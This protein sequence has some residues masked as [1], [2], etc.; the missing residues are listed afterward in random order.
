MEK[1]VI[2]NLGLRN[3]ELE[4]EIILGLLG[5]KGR[6]V[7]FLDRLNIGMFS[8]S[9]YRKSFLYIR[10]GFL[11]GKVV[12]IKSL[13]EKLKKD[14]PRRNYD[15]IVSKG[16][17]DRDEFSDI[18]NTLKQLEEKR[19]LYSIGDQIQAEVLA[20]RN[21]N[22][23]AGKIMLKLAEGFRDEKPNNPI[24]IM[25]TLKTELEKF[26]AGKKLVTGIKGLDDRL[27]A[28][29]K[30]HVWI[31]GARTGGGKSWMALQLAKNIAEQ[32]GHVAV[33]ST[34]MRDYENLGRIMGNEFKKGFHAFWQPETGIDFFET[35]NVK[36]YTKKLDSYLHIFDSLRTVEEI[37]AQCRK[38]LFQK[39]LNI[40]IIDFFQ[41]LDVR[42]KD[43]YEGF[44]RAA[45][46]LQSI[47]K[48]LGVTIIITSQLSNTFV[49]KAY[50][51]FNAVEYKNAGEIAASADV[52]LLLLEGREVGILPDNW[53]PIECVIAK[54]R[55]T[56]IREP[57]VP[58]IL[59]YPSGEIKDV[60]P[61]F[62]WIDKKIDEPD[63][64]FDKF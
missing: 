21:I 44:K 19:I 13:Y 26:H 52:G 5:S 23:I 7:E 61:E 42:G 27:P 18:V 1:S 20:D 32:E 10:K 39:K 55:H 36:Q 28:F 12:G 24:G 4:K 59:E 31:V 30:G 17:I 43:V 9:V 14:N 63:I 34:E 57:K 53:S 8:E 50:K 3:A 51:G 37:S 49:D 25:E 62:N 48:D 33:F 60:P 16:S 11:E 46:E 58:L 22:K 40:A 29:V 47:A 56:Y 2:Q 38:L 35:E 15:W 64:D 41:N 45:Q 54:S 6:M